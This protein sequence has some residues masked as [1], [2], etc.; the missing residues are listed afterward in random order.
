MPSTEKKVDRAGRSLIVV[1]PPSGRACISVGCI[2]RLGLRIFSVC[3][4]ENGGKAKRALQVEDRYDED[5]EKRKMR[6]V[7]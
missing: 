1:S 2:C 3:L 7:A 4:R 6:F 5:A